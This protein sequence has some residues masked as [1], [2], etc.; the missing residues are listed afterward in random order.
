MNSTSPEDNHVKRTRFTGPTLIAALIVACGGTNA[1]NTTGAGGA[2]SAAARPGIAKERL[3]SLDLAVQAYFVSTHGLDL[4]DIYWGDMH[5]HTYYSQDA[6]LQ[7][8]LPGSPAEANPA[9]VYTAARSRG[10]SFGAVADHA[11]APFPS[12]IPDSAPNVW[13]ST[14]A[15]SADA[16][17]DT[18]D[19]NGVFIPFMGYEYTNPFPCTDANPG[20]GV[21]E[22][23]GDC[24]SLGGN[25]S[26]EAHGHKN[27]IFRSI[28]GA[29]T[30]RVS[31]LDPASWTAEPSQ[32]T[33]QNPSAYCGFDTYSAFGPTNNAL[34]SWL[35][36]QG[37]DTATSGATG[38]ITIIHT[39]GNIHHNDWD[40]TDSEFV[41]NV[42]IFSQWGNSEGPAPA[43]CD[44]PD[45]LEVSLSAEAANNE[46]LLIRP[47][48]RKHWLLAGDEAYA[49][50]FVGGSDDHAGRPGGTGNGNGGVT[51]II[52]Q[53]PSR[54]AF[55]NGLIARRTIAATY[56]ESTGPIPLLFAVEAGG[57]H[58]LGG[59]VGNVAGSGTATVRVWAGAQA[60]QIQIVVDGCTVSTLTGPVQEVQIQGLN[61]LARHYIYVRARRMTTVADGVSGDAA[62]TQWNQTWSSPVYLRPATG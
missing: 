14:R 41:R 23:P 32:C 54:E 18:N 46:A 36:G 31:F 30:A 12:R 22:C 60:E 61:P 20:D 9:T 4:G 59:D 51:G 62:Q 17:D 44:D 25:E 27:V 7:A 1:D 34:W 38:A 49:L 21:Q 53:A 16:N 29:P 39:P 28:T 48:L 45:D 33:G 40:V 11:E 50:S 5:T 37:F 6:A 42:E 10:F 15:M 58:M 55:F 19:A 35:H 43:T 2:A 57:T 56:Y 13:E 26:C 3:L 47:Q 52:T 24:V 8:G